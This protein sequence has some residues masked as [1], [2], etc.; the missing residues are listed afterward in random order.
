MERA[1]ILYNGYE[2]DILPHMG[3]VTR[4]EDVDAD[5]V[6]QLFSVLPTMDA[7]Q[8]AYVQY[9]LDKTH[10]RVCGDGGA[11]EILGMKRSTLYAKIKEYGITLK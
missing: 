7:L 11:E 4:R 3:H 1:V 6:S 8:R 5:K 2:L 10:N 9:V